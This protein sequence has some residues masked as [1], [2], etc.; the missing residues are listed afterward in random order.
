MLCLSAH[1]IIVILYRFAVFALG[2]RSFTT[3]QYCAFGKLM[4]KMMEGMGAQRL[5]AIGEGDDLGSQDMAFSNWAKQALHVSHSLSIKCII[6]FECDFTVLHY[7]I[8]DIRML[9]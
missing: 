2:S 5:I 9:Q 4:D 1:Y 6:S 7:L 8:V 3:I